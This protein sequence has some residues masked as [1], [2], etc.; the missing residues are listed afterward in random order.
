MN[1]KNPRCQNEIDFTKKRS[2]AQFCSSKCYKSFHNYKYKNKER[3]ITSSKVGNGSNIIDLYPP[4]NQGIK[5]AT[6]KKDIFGG[7]IEMNES[8]GKP[9]VEPQP[10]TREKPDFDLIKFSKKFNFLRV[11]KKEKGSV[12]M[13]LDAPAGAGK[14]TLLFQ[15]IGDAAKN[16]NKVLFISLEENPTSALFIEKVNRFWDEESENNIK[17]LDHVSDKN[18]LINLCND[19]NVIA[20]DSFGKLPKGTEVENFRH[21]VNGAFV[22]AIFQQTNEGKTRGGSVVGYD[23]DMVGKMKV[24]GEGAD[25]ESWL[26]FDKMRYYGEKQGELLYNA[27]WEPEVKREE[28]EEPTP[29]ITPPIT[30]LPTPPPPTPPKAEKNNLDVSFKKDKNLEELKKRFEKIDIENREANA[31]LCQSIDRHENQEFNPPN[32]NINHSQIL[33]TWVEWTLGLGA[34]GFF[35]WHLVKE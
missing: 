19:Y 26:Y 28:E 20:I 8:T 30:P 32:K 7:D 11:E 4:K 29:P 10:V 31:Q 18:E 17:T 25:K 5:K 22:I 33:P 12:F 13:S 35:V 9:K 24:V 6:Q 16:G 27:F 2:D 15:I 3:G 14:T 34:A 1:C 23:A 21:D